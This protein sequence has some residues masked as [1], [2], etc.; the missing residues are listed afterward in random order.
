MLTTSCFLIFL[1]SASLLINKVGI[2]KDSKYYESKDDLC[3]INLSSWY[4]EYTFLVIVKLLIT[5]LK[6]Y[7]LKKDRKEHI[8]LTLFDL[9]VLNLAFTIL[10]IK[11]NIMYFS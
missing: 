8:F 11:A 3:G 10:F 7:Y 5:A 2:S 6:Y 9:I 1:F 4:L